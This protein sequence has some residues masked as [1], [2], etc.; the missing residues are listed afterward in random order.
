MA[1]SYDTVSRALD[2]YAETLEGLQVAA[3]EALAR[4]KLAECQR[5][6]ADS[7]LQAARSRVTEL[8]KQLVQARADEETQRDLCVY[9]PVPI[10]PE[11]D[12]NFQRHLAY[13]RE[14]ESAEQHARRSKDAAHQRR[15]DAQC[16]L[17]RAK[18]WAATLRQ[19]HCEAEQAAAAAIAGALAHGLRDPTGFAKLWHD[20]EGLG[21]DIADLA[22]DAWDEI[23]DAAAVIY[24]CADIIEKATAWL[25]IGLVVVACVLALSGAGVPLVFM[26]LTWTAR[27]WQVSD[28]A[29]KVKTA[30]GALLVLGNHRDAEGKEVNGIGLAADYGVSKALKGGADQHMKRAFFPDARKATSWWRSGV[31]TLHPGQASDAAQQAWHRRRAA[32]Q[33]A[34]PLAMDP[35]NKYVT[36][37]INGEVIAAKRAIEDKVQSL[38][39]G[40]GVPIVGPCYANQPAGVR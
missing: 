38:W 6:T 30:A 10:P 7:D 5:A 3:D 24:T 16:D 4:A 25:A 22:D 36:K 23:L 26:T 9:G 28:K 20:I 34:K 8:Q 15:G 12:P 17:D 32:A 18:R 31:K 14:V 19:Q 29:G 13:R 33:I 2:R 37:P 11:S 40:G 1:D 35:F 27:A 21:G 39:T